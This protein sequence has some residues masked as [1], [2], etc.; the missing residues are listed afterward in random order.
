MKFVPRDLAK[1]FSNKMD[2]F[3]EIKTFAY[4]RDLCENFSLKSS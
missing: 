4:L 3:I 2:F 1:G